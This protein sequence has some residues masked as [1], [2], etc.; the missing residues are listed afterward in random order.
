MDMLGENPA[1]NM[2]DKH[3]RIF[4]RNDAR[5]PQY[6]SEDAEIINSVISE[7]TYINGT[8][9]NSVIGSGVTVE[10]GAVV[11][12]SVIMDDV[13]VEANATVDYAILD[14]DTTVKAGVRVGK[15]N[16]GKDAI[17]VIAKGKTIENDMMEAAK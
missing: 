8:V 3:F 13:T 2:R 4:S 12:E 9:I 11:R 14:S 15:E 1:I 7:G 10:K 16:A 17:L 6:I 5:S